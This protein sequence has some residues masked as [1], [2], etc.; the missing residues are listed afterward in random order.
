MS[1]FFSLT[2]PL[3]LSLSH[4]LSFVFPYLF[5]FPIRLSRHWKEDEVFYHLWI[6]KKFAV[7]FLKAVR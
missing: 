6:R 2:L 7:R 3:P 5:I 4:F 1:I